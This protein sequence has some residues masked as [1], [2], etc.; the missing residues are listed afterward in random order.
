MAGEGLVYVFDQARD[1]G[2]FAAPG[3]AGH[4]YHAA[5]LYPEPGQDLGGKVELLEGLDLAL[6]IAEDRAGHAVLMEDAAPE[7]ADTLKIYRE[8]YLA[9]R[10]EYLLLLVVQYQIGRA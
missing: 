9:F 10:I 1:G 6:D 2:R 4:E 8:I 5:L 3:G 7:S